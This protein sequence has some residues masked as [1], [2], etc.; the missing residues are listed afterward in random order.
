M[1]M[2]K[3]LVGRS[4]LTSTPTGL[5]SHSCVR[6]LI[7]PFSLPDPMSAR[8]GGTLSSKSTPPFGTRAGTRKPVIY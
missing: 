3:A 7:S 1:Q 4:S 2:N 8:D 6:G 5:T